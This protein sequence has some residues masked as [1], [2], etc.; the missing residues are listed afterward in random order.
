[1]KLRSVGLAPWVL[2]LGVGCLPDN[3]SA[4]DTAGTTASADS[5]AGE[6]E[7]GDGGGEL[8]GC[9]PG[10]CTML[11]AVQ[12]LDDRIEVFVPDHPD[13]AY[14]GAISVDLEPNEC[15]GCGLGDNGAGRLDEPFGIA[16]AGGFLHVLTGH[17]PTRE[18]GGLVAFP[19]GFFEGI[20]TGTT[21]PVTDYFVGSQFQ[22]GVV[23][24]SL[25]EREAIFMHQ[26]ASGRL[27][28]GVFNNDLFAGEDSWTLPGKL[29]VIDPA[30]P[31]GELG[32]VT[33]DGL[34]GGACQGASQVIG[35]G[36]NALA[37]ACDGNERVAIVDATN[38]GGGTVADAAAGLGN[39]FTCPIPGVMMGT[40]RLR[41]LAPDGS[42][43]FAVLEG[44]TPT[45]LQASARLWHMT[46]NASGGCTN[47]GGSPLELG[48]G[49]DWQLGEIV[50]LPAAGATW[51]LAAGSSNTQGGVRGIFVARDAGD[52]LELCP[53]PIPGF[54]SAWQDVNGNAIE[55]FALAV[56]S[57]A[58]HL[59]VGAGPYIAPTSG[60]GYGKVLWATLAGADPCSLTADVDDLTDG[61]PGQAPAPNPNDASTFR[62][63]PNVVVI[64]EIP[65]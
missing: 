44:P 22:G 47:E 13:S 16:R 37:V 53:A 35:I 28:V 65:G 1:M 7:G 12:T 26:H 62:R 25:G 20:T 38:L 19:L 41:Y 40:K 60:V 58:T 8:L 43:G 11:L 57:D 34:D 39:G 48:S 32:T 17:Y 51:L 52:G 6:T 59:A 3:P 15:D 18:A 46:P 56:T 21:V 5:T 24:R 2:A 61:E 9:P 10:G 31:S 23:Q 42:G 30:D 29:L 63:G 50:Q 49:G 36:P 64:Q 4:D 27:V 33:L 45:N 14:R 55:P 54:E